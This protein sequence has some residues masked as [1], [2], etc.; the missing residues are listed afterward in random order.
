MRII[1]QG[2]SWTKEICLSTCVVGNLESSQLKL[3]QVADKQL[4]QET[5]EK[6]GKKVKEE[7]R[8][9]ERKLKSLKSREVDKEKRQESGREKMV[10]DHTTF[11]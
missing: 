9:K 6:R 7:E 4:T 10:K 3:V 11:L 2:S 8:K 1:F 5:K